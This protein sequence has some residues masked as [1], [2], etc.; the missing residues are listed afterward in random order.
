M[1]DYI[2]SGLITVRA[3]TRVRAE[4]EAAARAAAK[5]RQVIMSAN[6]GYS[7][8]VLVLPANTD[9]RPRGIHAELE[10]E[11]SE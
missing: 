4:D 10:E 7:E 8:Q 11:A 2:V 6:D 1:K 3:Y 5:A 9:Q